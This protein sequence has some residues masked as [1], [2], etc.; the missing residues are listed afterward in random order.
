MKKYILLSALI[1]SSLYAYSEDIELYVGNANLR[2]QT[3]PQVL[4]IVDTSGSMTG[5]QTIKT[6]YNPAKTYK[7]LGSYSGKGDKYLYYVVGT[8]TSLPSVDSPTEKRRFLASLNNCSTAVSRLNK[9]G[10]YTGRI[11]EYTFQGNSGSWQDIPDSDGTSISII[12]CEDDISL[13]L[14]HIKNSTTVEHNSNKVNGSVTFGYPIDGLGTVASPVYYDT[15]ITKVDASWGGDVVT[16]YTDN[17][18]RWEQ[19]TKYSNGADI[20]TTNTTRIAIAQRTLTNLIDSIPSV[21]FGLEVYNFNRYSDSNQSNSHGGR[22]AFGI[23]E[24]TATAK[25]SL[26]SIIENDLHASGWT[27][28]CESYYEAYRYFAG[29]PVK[30]GS[31]DENGFNGVKYH[32]KTLPDRDKSI[33]SGGNYIAPYKGCSNEVFVI[34]ITDGEPTNDKASDGLVKAL[35]TGATPSSTAVDVDNNYLPA[36]AE[37]VHSNDINASLPGT[38]IATL[39]T[40]GFSEGASAATKLLE[41][42][43]TKGGG[44]YYDATDPTKLGSA[45]QKALSSIL[46]V[47]T[48][49]TAPSVATNSF[50]RTESL[51]SAYYGMFIPNNGARWKGNLKKLKIKDDKQ[52]DREGNSAVDASG[53]IIDTAKTYWQ[54]SATPDGNNVN[55][56]GV[57]GMFS[58][59]TKNSRKV[60]SDIGTSNI[61][62]PLTYDNLETA[63]GSAANVQSLIG[64]TDTI[65]AKEYLNWALGI[66]VDDA[67]NDGDKDDYRPDLF[68]DPLHSKP[69]VV[70]YGVSKSNPDIRILVGTNSGVLHMFKD[71]GATVDE[72]WA[73]MPQK[74]FPEIKPLRDNLPASSKVYGID[75][76]ITTHLID[77]DLDGSISSTGDK[78]WMFLGLRRGGSSYYALDITDPD[79]PK[80]MWEIKANTGDFKELGQ[81]WSQPQVTYSALNIS[82]GKAKPVLIFGAGYSIA[83]DITGPGTPDSVGRGIYM[84]D[85]ESG[86]LLWSVTPAATTGKNT[87]FTGFTDSIPSRIGILDSDGDGL[88]DR[89]YTGD[90]GGNVFRIDMPGDNPFSSTTPWTAFKLAELG[91][92]TNVDDRRFFDA[93]SIVRTF[94]TDTYESTIGTT[95]IVTSK[96]TPYEAVLLGSG[97]RSTPSSTDTNDEFFMIQDENIITQ[98]FVAGAVSPAKDIPT[99]ITYND[100]ADFT[101][102][103]YGSLTTTADIKALDLIVS[104]KS[105]WRYNYESAG[106]KSTAGA[107]VL[108]GVAYFTSFT[109]AGTNSCSLV[110]GEGALYAV[111]LYKGTKFFSWKKIVTTTTMPDTPTPYIPH[112]DVTSVPPGSPPGSDSPTIRLLTGSGEGEGTNPGVINTGVGPS[113][114]R[115]YQYITE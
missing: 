106:E 97:D 107:I 2:A 14:E 12:D 21:Q 16:I 67:D 73:F 99:V 104:Q 58:A 115:T 10:F 56:G 84:V 95:T 114:Y 25:K 101:S 42:A 7:T 113:I 63:A 35:H 108:K 55:A 62:T 66:D 96:E 48:T 98:S 22:I 105:G 103:P 87:Q 88:V 77:A 71:S 13:D 5:S 75:G 65:E 18:L 80:L 40:V 64:V 6:P 81:T 45:L 30:Y 49:F 89:L 69:V 102:D 83:K 26:L 82:G 33:E 37:Y 23:Q 32:N 39:Y 44:K 110:N 59:K 34:L 60:Y 74:F 85:A 100:L 17:Y 27:P 93:P 15:D 51:D 47:N 86:A 109:P 4:L 31:Q 72:S 53:S 52:V 41:A 76:R 1:F 9:V 112:V 57:V 94:F 3:K 38:Q 46:A 11:K 20:G 61:L 54:S 43:A 70:N 24:M 111:D 8:P 29:L 68:G 19:G 92:T 50:D 28:L 78:A 91:G 79:T 36:L 90:T